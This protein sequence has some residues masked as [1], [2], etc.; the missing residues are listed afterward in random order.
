AEPPDQRDVRAP[1]LLAVADRL[2]GEAATNALRHDGP[3]TL[4]RISTEHGA[5]MLILRITSEPSS[6]PRPWA[7]R[8]AGGF[9]LLSLAE[10]LTRYGG[11]LVHGP[12]APAGWQIEA[13]FPVSARGGSPAAHAGRRC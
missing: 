13:S 6:P 9:G 11:T 12:R 2:L 5:E 7:G 10:D 1:P 4:L 3:G 8:E